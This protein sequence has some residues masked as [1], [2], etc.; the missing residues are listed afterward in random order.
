M[1]LNSDIFLGFI[2]HYKDLHQGTNQ[3]TTFSYHF[4]FLLIL[5]TPIIIPHYSENFLGFTNVLQQLLLKHVGKGNLFNFPTLVDFYP[6]IS[7]PSL[8]QLGHSI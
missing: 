1:P 4:I 2:S 6:V 3:V 8:P 5:V 7:P